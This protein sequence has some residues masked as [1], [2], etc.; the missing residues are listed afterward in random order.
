MPLSEDAQAQ[1]AKVRV[2]VKRKLS[3][4]EHIQQT[5]PIPI[6]K[7]RTDKVILSYRPQRQDLLDPDRIDI[8][9]LMSV[10]R[11]YN[12][13]VRGDQ[14][15]MCKALGKKLF[16]WTYTC[17]PEERVYQGFMKFF[18]WKIGNGALTRTY[19][20]VNTHDFYTSVPIAEIPVVYQFH[21]IEVDKLYSFDIRSLVLCRDISYES[22][23]NPYT[24]RPFATDILQQIIRKE[25]WLTRFKYPLQFAEP[26]QN[27]LTAEE[28][29]ERQAINA[30]S[31]I[32]EHQYADYRWFTELDFTATKQL[33]HELYEIWHYR[34]PMQS[35][36][37]ADMVYGGSVFANWPTVN[38]YRMSSHNKLQQELLHDIYRL[39]T[40]GKT[41]DH[42]KSGCYMFMLGLVLVSEDAQTSHPYLFQAAYIDDDDF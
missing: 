10:C 5:E 28:Q 16:K 33:Y 42:R 38:K 15:R 12:I 18:L 17:T 36:Y 27:E 14:S 4:C 9:S 26:E 8:F 24:D 13:I 32:S 34:L 20:P 39:V 23:R 25:S 6:V 7:P 22:F 11:H 41:D 29:V 37:K 3:V 31:R 35:A 21:V 2:K 30:F 19:V 40:E 1:R